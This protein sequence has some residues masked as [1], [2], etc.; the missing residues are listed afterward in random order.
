MGSK[1]IG[2]KPFKKVHLNYFGAIKGAYSEV[3]RTEHGDSQI[4][5][6]DAEAEIAENHFGKKNIHRGKVRDNRKAAK[7][8]FRLYGTGDNIT[9]NLVYPKLDDTELRLYLSKR[10]GFKPEAREIWFL[11]IGQ[12]TNLYLGSMSKI[13]WNLISQEREKV[14]DKDKSNYQNR[15]ENTLSKRKQ[16]GRSESSEN[17]SVNYSRNHKIAI[18]R[19]QKANF[20]CEATGEKSFVA[21]STGKP[22][23]EAHHLIPVSLQDEFEN[24]LDRIENVF[25]LSPN[26][27]RA[28]HHGTPKKKRNLID[29]LINIRPSIKEIYN[30]KKEDL[31][32]IYDANRD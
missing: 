8:K 30:I 29:K 28:I 6:V 13:K 16:G 22:F 17:V 24:G 32:L 15:V 25:A 7:K 21:E 2:T 1:Y 20:C 11:Y 23:V 4:T 27:H 5:L 10:K 26:A 9:L 12:D 14:K 31:Y 19:F 3:T 18:S